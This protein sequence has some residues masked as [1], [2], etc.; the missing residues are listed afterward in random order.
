MLDFILSKGWGFYDYFAEMENLVNRFSLRTGVELGVYYTPLPDVVIDTDLA[1]SHAR[2]T[3]Y[4]AVGDRIPN[5][6]EKVASLGVTWNHATGFYAGAR[7]LRKTRSTILGS[8][9]LSAVY[10]SLGR[11]RSEF[12]LR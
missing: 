5:A 11:I 10:S 9:F 3:D 1:W 8:I 4:D 6:I 12:R 2:F 7:T